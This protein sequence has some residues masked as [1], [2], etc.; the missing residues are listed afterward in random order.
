VV[1]SGLHEQLAAQSAV[2]P[3]PHVVVAW[4]SGDMCLRW[5]AAGMLEAELPSSFGFRPGRSAHDTLQV[6]FDEAWSQGASRLP[7]QPPVARMAPT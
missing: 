6:L 4:Q 1:L 7:D 2:A 3:G 5:T